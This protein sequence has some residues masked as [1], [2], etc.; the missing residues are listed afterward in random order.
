MSTS[1]RLREERER[2]GLSQEKFGA[3]GGVLKRAQINYEKGERAP[4]SAYLAAI[5]EA[6]ADVLYVLTGQRN[7]AM[8]ATDSAEQ[9]LLDSYRRCGPAARQT[10]IQTAALLSAGMHV[11]DQS[12][13]KR[14]GSVVSSVHGHAAGRDV[15]VNQKEGS[16]EQARGRKPTRPRSRA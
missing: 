10:L 3:L 16:N 13:E 15:N 9:V 7:A 1:D 11:R 5:A 6:G 12:P 2:L 14:E 8:P 4:D